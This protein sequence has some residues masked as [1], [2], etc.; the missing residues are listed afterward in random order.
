[1]TNLLDQ[2]I[3]QQGLEEADS[4]VFEY[5]SWTMEKGRKHCI[6]ELEAYQNHQENGIEPNHKRQLWYPPVKNIEGKFI[7]TLPY[8]GSKLTLREPYVCSSES[9]ANNFVEVAI[10]AVKQGDLDAEIL[11]CHKDLSNE[12]KQAFKEGKMRASLVDK[13]NTVEDFY[14]EV[15]GETDTI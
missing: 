5:S 11:K 15:E 3:E 13:T 14:T 10:Q 4:S 6:D 7:V 2:H 8:G 1:M 9:Q 12:S